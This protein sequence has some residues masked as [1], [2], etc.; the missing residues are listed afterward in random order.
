M[1][2]CYF[3]LKRVHIFFYTYFGLTSYI[4]FLL[5]H[6]VYILLLPPLL[7]P[8]CHL[9]KILPKCLFPLFIFKSPKYSLLLPENPQNIT[10]ILGKT[11][12]SP[13]TCICFYYFNAFSIHTIVVNIFPILGFFSPYISFL[14]NF[15]LN[16]IGTQFHCVNYY[17]PFR[18]PFVFRFSCRNPSSILN[19]TVPLSYLLIPLTFQTSPAS[20]TK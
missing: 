16:T 19:K 2:F 7:P 20:N 12:I 8:P 9:R 3:T 1:P 13:T 14:L 5:P 17:Y 4:F 15:G 18:Y 10:P 6:F 11:N